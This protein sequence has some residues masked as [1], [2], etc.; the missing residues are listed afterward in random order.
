MTI[1]RTIL[2]ITTSKLW[3]LYQ[4]DIKNAFLHGDLKEEVHMRLHPEYE[5]SFKA[6]VNK[7]RRSLYGLQREPKEWFEKFKSVLLH[8]AFS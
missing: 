4:I 2:T 5:T 8:L 7:L 1:V 3:P 6:D